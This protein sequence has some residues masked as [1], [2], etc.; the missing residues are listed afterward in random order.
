MASVLL[1]NSIFVL[2]FGN[3]F[4]ELY[5]NRTT[6]AELEHYGKLIYSAYLAN[7]DS[8]DTVLNELENKNTVVI[9]Y[10]ALEDKKTILYMSRPGGRRL[11]TPLPEGGPALDMLNRY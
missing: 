4:M 3:F 9:I 8:I 5:Y 2:L 1:F 6:S 7:P 10:S 11:A